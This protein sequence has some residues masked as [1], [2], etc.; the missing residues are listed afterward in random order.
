MSHKIR[1][2]PEPCTHAKCGH[3][4]AWH[5]PECL[6]HLRHLLQ[7][8]REA[9]PDGP[10]PWDTNTYPAGDSR[11]AR[12]P[13]PMD[14][15]CVCGATGCETTHINSNNVVKHK[16]DH[17]KFPMPRRSRTAPM[18]RHD[19]KANPRQLELESVWK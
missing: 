8:H 7:E 17:K 16:A 9:C 2:C 6:A 11:W 5:K 15:W 14:M 1:P 13:L 10:D 3:L 4:R 18:W 12:G 19:P